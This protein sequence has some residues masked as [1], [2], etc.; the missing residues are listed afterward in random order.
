[1]GAFAHN[2]EYQLDVDIVV[3]DE[4][5]MVDANLG[6][7]LIQSLQNGTKLII[8][9]DTGQ[10]EGIGVGNLLQIGRASCRERV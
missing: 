8:L 3:V 7:S 5:S 1:M 6:N 4:F 9:G 2:K 10:L